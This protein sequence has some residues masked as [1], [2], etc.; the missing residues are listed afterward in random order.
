M[1]PVQADAYETLGYGKIEI[2]KESKD[3]DLNLY[4]GRGMRMAGAPVMTSFLWNKTR[5]DFIIPNLWAKAVMK[6]IGFY[7]VD[8]RKLWPVYGT[9]GGLS[10][11]QIFY[12]AGSFNCFVRRPDAGSYISGLTIPTLY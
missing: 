8:G 5:I 11:A 12:L 6:D 3:Q 10:A 2:R 1:H 4:F 7:T 9:S